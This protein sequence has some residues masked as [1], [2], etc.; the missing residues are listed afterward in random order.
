[1]SQ[2]K[3]YR[4]NFHTHTKVNDFL[5]SQP[6]G[7][8]LMG[9]DWAQATPRDLRGFLLAGDRAAGGGAAHTHLECGATDLRVYRNEKDH[10]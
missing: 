9:W 5:G 1:M 8:F 3:Y 4:Q 2:L 10:S 6:V 7:D